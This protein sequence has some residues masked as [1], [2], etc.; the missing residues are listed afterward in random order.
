LTP[1]DIKADI[2]HSRNHADDL[3]TPFPMGKCAYEGAFSLYEG[4][5]PRGWHWE[6]LPQPPHFDG[7][8]AAA[9]AYC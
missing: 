7:F 4:G 8:M 5:F 6:T 3:T 9:I 2:G 1:S